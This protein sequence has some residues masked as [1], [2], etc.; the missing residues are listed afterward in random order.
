MPSRINRIYWD[1]NALVS[2]LKTPQQLKT[3]KIASFFFKVLWMGSL[4][5]SL[6][7]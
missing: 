3:A 7:P 1:A 5:Y 4:R 2:N 6:Q